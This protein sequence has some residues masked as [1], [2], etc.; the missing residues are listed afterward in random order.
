MPLTDDILGT[1]ADGSTNEDYC[2]YCYTAG[3]FTRPAD[4]TME[5]MIEFCARFND[6]MNEH[7]GLNLTPEQAKERMRQLFPT[8][9]RWKKRA[10]TN[11]EILYVLLPDYAAHEAVYLSEA[12]A[13]DETAI[14]VSP[15]Y[16]NKTVAPSSEAVRSIGGFRTLPDYSFDT[17]PDDYA[18]LVLIGG[19]GWATPIAERVVP[20]VRNAI[21]RGKTVG[22]ICNAASFMA[23]HGFLNDVRHTGNG[24]G[25]LRQW[26][27]ANY[28][29]AAGYVRAQAVAD[30]N[31]VTANGSATLEFAKE[32]LL[33]LG[34]DTADRIEMYYRFNKLGFCELFK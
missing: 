9:K 13:A 12:I 32:L 14:R 4:C 25:Q 1:N 11:N 24:I 23:K 34:N 22:A 6:E 30:K 2:T 19:F 17:M 10:N 31:I 16:V 7:T 15:K 18:A 26:G 27:G 33:L 3:A 8:L 5:Q 20:I 29:N 28:T 21:E